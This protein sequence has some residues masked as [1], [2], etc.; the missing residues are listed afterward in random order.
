MAGVSGQSGLAIPKTVQERVVVLRVEINGHNHRYYVLD[1]PTVPDA[2][3]DRLMVEL[4][5]L[6]ADFPSLVTPESPTQRVGGAP[7]AGFAQVHHEL[8]MLSL[9]N[10]FSDESVNDFDQRVRARL[11]TES[12]QRYAVEPKLDG[13]AISIVYEH[14][15]LVRAATRG[16]GETGEDVTHNVRTIHSVPL[17]LRGSD[18]PVYL[19]VRGEIF[20]PRA[21]FEALN[22]RA[23]EAGEKTFVNPRNAAAGSLRQLD[24]RL[25][26]TRP[27]DMFVYSL[28][29]VRGAPVGATHTEALARLEGWG[30][31]V[32]PE[33]AVVE[34]VP[35]CLDYYRSI[36]DQR[37]ALPYDID[38]VVYKVDDFE[39]QRELGFVS[40]APRW[41]IAHKFPA[42]EQL[43]TVEAIQWQVG[44]TGAVTPVA[45]LAPVF[46]GGVT[47]SNATL[48]NIDELQRKDV[49]VGDTVIV[50]RAG[51]V[52]P[53]VVRVLP[54]R[55]SKGA[56]K[57]RLPRK[58]PVCRSAVIRPEGEAAARCSGG[59]FCSA[60]RKEAI[61]HFASRRALDIEGLGS[62]LIDQ[63]V[64][65]EIVKAPDDLYRLT[66]EDLAELE[67][68]GPK[69]A[70][71]LVASL[72]QS[73]QTTFAKFL[74]A[75]GIREVGEA[76]ALNLA[77]GF[78]TLDALTV[79]SEE[80]LQAVPDVGPVVAAHLHAFFR[81]P[82]N[83]T[84]ID[85]L[86][87]LG[88]SWPTP[89][90]PAVDASLA[91]A[92]LTVVLTGTL[93]SMA[94]AEAKAKIQALGGRVTGSVSKE[95]DLVI[96]GEQ[97]GRKLKSAQDL[98]VKT[99]AEEAFLAMLAD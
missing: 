40:R 51:D 63:L 11:G 7:I 38:G 93:Q 1:D 31:K 42:Q 70:A 55:R 27:L 98:G 74:Y 6:E 79:A 72:D 59:L 32:C 30:L 23:R 13:T 87:Q 94:R 10:A 90:A 58:C 41:A 26:A 15:K 3:Y 24:P 12:A 43:T 75:L 35:G 73:K 62:K 36:A 88:M 17:V 82:H 14:G 18:Y 95:T 69:S 77:T 91:F 37:D 16:D 33:S 56:R 76:T 66:A 78:R 44:R 28:G 61:K 68:M 19:E 60:Q 34:G 9:D 85:A 83:A 65:R 53:E 48:H 54:E 52:I 29:V 4:G 57:V 49:R 64:D 50:R 39:S 20:M 21:G 46:V 84:V 47:V 97:A 8:P 5:E 2:E 92:D 86:L 22:R 25:T 96:Y 89:E 80:E 71:N 99:M 81:E 67:R 45:R